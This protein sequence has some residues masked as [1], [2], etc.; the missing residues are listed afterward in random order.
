MSDLFLIKERLAAVF[1]SELTVRVPGTTFVAGRRSTADTGVV[2]VVKVDRV[3]EIAPDTGVYNGEVAIIL[4]RNM[5]EKP[6][7]GT[8]NEGLQSKLAADVEKALNQI[9]RPG[10]DDEIGIVLNGW[11]IDDIAEASDAQD[12]ADIVFLKV[13]CQLPEKR[14]EPDV[15]HPVG[16]S[17]R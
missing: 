12:Y 3:D 16:D 8:T 9:P 14:G 1:V 7:A 2:G 10:V 5:D 17:D 15:Q 4:L 13:G 6:P 11:V